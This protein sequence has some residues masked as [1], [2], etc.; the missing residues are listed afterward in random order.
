MRNWRVSV[1][2]G[3][4]F[5]SIKLAISVSPETP[6]TTVTR[7]DEEDRLSL[8]TIDQKPF[9]FL[10]EK[11]EAIFLRKS[12]FCLRFKPRTADLYFLF[13]DFLRLKRAPVEGWPA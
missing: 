4:E 1:Q 10:S 7:G 5:R 13:V 11:E 6:S 3:G 9:F 12:I 2:Y 8:R